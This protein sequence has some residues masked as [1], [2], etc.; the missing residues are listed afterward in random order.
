MPEIFMP[1]FPCRTL[2]LVSLLLFAATA[3]PLVA[4]ARDRRP[5]PNYRELAAARPMTG[6]CS[7][8]LSYQSCQTC[9][10]T[11]K[12]VGGIVSALCK[13]ATRGG[14]ALV[15]GWIG[16]TLGGVF[17]DLTC[18]PMMKDSDCYSRC[19]GKD[20]DPAPIACADPGDPDEPGVCRQICEQGQHN[21]GAVGCPAN[22]RIAL[23]CCI[24][25][26]DPPD[27]DCSAEFCPGPLCPEE[28]D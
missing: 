23:T 20:G 27:E 4:G 17:G 5:D 26:Y 15:G 18:E 24:N 3:A 7:I 13:G 22:G 1:S 11:S 14:G 2:V 19:V 9:C 12:R 6:Q 10:D 8:Q 25:E 28:C 16:A 21:L